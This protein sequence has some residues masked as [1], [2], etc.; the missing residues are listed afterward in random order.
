[1]YKLGRM[2][3]KE[4]FVIE[5]YGRKCYYCGKPLNKEVFSFDHKIPVSKGGN[6]SVFNLVPACKRCNHL[7]GNKTH[8]QFRERRKYARP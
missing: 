1:M 3:S 5:K 6:N 2:P 8:T 7:K 4:D